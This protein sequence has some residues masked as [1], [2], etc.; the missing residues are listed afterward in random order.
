MILVSNLKVMFLGG[1][2][3]IGKNMTV[4]EYGDDIIVLDSGL[5]FPTEDLPG[6][7]LVVPDITY[8]VNNKEKVRGIV[9]T[10][11]HEDHIGGLPYVLSDI[12]TT[13]YGS[14]LT[15]AL[16][17]NKMREHI[18]VK[19][20]AVSIK[21]KSVIKL[22]VFTVE[23]IRVNH[24]I[25]GCM[26]LAITTPVGIVV[27][28]GDYKVDY[29]P[30]GCEIID[31]HRFAEL[32][33][34]GVLLMMADST[35]AERP[36]HSMSE[37]TVGKALDVIFEENATRRIFVA[38][39][40]SNIYRLQQI[41]DLAVK[42]KRKIAFSGRSMLNVTGTAIKIGELIVNKEIIIDIEKADKYAD[43]ELVI[44]TTGSQGEPMSA[45]TRM[46]S[47][48]FNK[49]KIGD[50]DTIILSASPIPGN[51]KMINRVINNLIKLGSNVIYSEIAD[52]HV[53]GHAYVEEIKLMHALVKP[54]FFI[55][56]HG[57]YK[58]LKAHSDIAISMGMEARDIIIP[59]IGL[60]VDVNKNLLKVSG[61]IPAGKRLVDGLGL[62]DTDSM[63]LKDRKQLA[64]DGLCIVVLGVSDTLEGIV[65]GPDIITRGLIYTAE[66]SN[67]INEAKEAILAALSEIDVKQ[68]ERSELKNIIRKALAMYFFKKTKR[69]PMILPILLEQ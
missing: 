47:G 11:G 53:S 65:S 25:S 60:V 26:A 55:P 67:L 13:I 46:S 10:H 5:T 50:N 21:E 20:K 41:F 27:F 1:V 40:A 57:E 30:I 4:L 35:N 39:F 58:H 62:G 36:G 19:Y 64:E 18:K 22:G 68:I 16:V 52:V 8:L 32:G 38:T 61:T 24:S 59:D 12:D 45:L 7:D 54:R 56:V 34:R 23:F 44:V 31:L 49:I 69:R 63:V 6:I 37:R 28:T 17:E 2:G 3:E 48:D 29:T 42:H 15:L 43:K 9:L 33:K 51:E 14:R 66:A